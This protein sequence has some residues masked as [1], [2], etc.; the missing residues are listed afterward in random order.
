MANVLKISD[1]TTLGLHAMVCLADQH[2]HVKPKAKSTRE[3]ASTLNASEAHLAKV[4]QRL[5]HAGL[6]CSARGPKGGFTLAREADE[7]TL[8]EVYESLVGPFEPS[9]CLF[10]EPVCRRSTC[11]MGGLVE[12]IG[13]ELQA[14][15]ERTTLA[16]LTKGGG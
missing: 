7:I 12:K 13:K 14:Y 5:A 9:K 3:I 1:A 11:I 6:L 4:L 2:L 15:L 8:L 10:P 16:S